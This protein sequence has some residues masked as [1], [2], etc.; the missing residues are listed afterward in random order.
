MAWRDQI[1]KGS[2]KGINFHTRI[3][4]TTISR[5][6]VNHSY[7]LTNDVFSEDLGRQADQYSLE[8]FFVGDNYFA[9]R[10]SFIA[11]CSDG[12]VGTLIHPYLGQKEVLVQNYSIKENAED[13]G[14]STLSV[15][16]VEKGSSKFPQIT[17]DSTFRLNTAVNTVQ[18]VS[19]TNFTQNAKLLGVTDFARTGMT[20]VFNPV[21]RT[22]DTLLSGG[23]FINNISLN[24]I[25][26]FAQIRANLNSLLNPVPT[27]LSS[28]PAFAN[29]FI[30]TL[31][32][33]NSTTTDGKAVRGIFKAGRDAESVPIPVNT[34]QEEIHNSNQDISVRLIETICIACEVE[35]FLKSTFESRDEAIN[36]RNDIATQIDSLLNTSIEDEEYQAL[37][38][39][40]SETIKFLPPENLDLPSIRKIRINETLPSLVMTYQVYNSIELDSDIISRN[41]IINPNFVDSTKEYEVLISG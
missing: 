7:V 27:L 24:G 35:T 9:E 41:A 26:S 13:G 28:A 14:L 3:T 21:L 19:E 29:L 25:S 30:Q 22:M 17:E 5:N 37:K 6:V 36:I 20:K 31:R 10:D 23:S 2:F 16:F 4:E 18:T 34:Q 1:Q 40:K 8:I 33:I 38:T 12:K 39:L 32:L 11:A 15:S